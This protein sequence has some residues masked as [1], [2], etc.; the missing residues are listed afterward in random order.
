MSD[1]TIKPVDSPQL[2][3]L[4]AKLAA[5]EAARDA[6]RA[7]LTDEDKAEQVLR[8][9]LAE[10]DE[11]REQAEKEKRD[12]ALAR[13]LETMQEKLGDAVKLRE[14]VLKDPYPEHSFILRHVGAAYACFEKELGWIANGKKL[15]IGDVRRKFV[16]AC[17]V[18][19]NGI[20]DFTTATASGDSEG[21]RLAAFLKSHQG[22][23]TMLSNEASE[24]AGLAKEQRKS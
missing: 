12:L 23:V 24:L 8:A 1:D 10:R 13:R 16:T 20:T 15:E 3:A 21:Y 17:I 2:Q 5:A 22:A 6:A 11:E 18:D 9:Q 14:V 19:W 4:R 7:A